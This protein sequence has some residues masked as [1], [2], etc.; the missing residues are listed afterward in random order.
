MLSRFAVDDST[1]R[2]YLAQRA[3]RR[4]Q[5]VP[6]P[7]FVEVLG[8]TPHSASF[9]QNALASNVG[10]P[11]DT[12]KLEQDLSAVVG[13]GRFSSLN[14][15]MVQRNGM[16]GLQIEG[17]EKTFAP[18]I[19]QPG[20]F[21]DGSQYN[22]VLFSI[23]ARLT[24]LDLGGYRSEW[25]TDV[26]L[27]STYAVDSEYHKFLSPKSRWF[28]EPRIFASSSPLEL[29]SKG[30]RLAQYGVGQ[31]GAE[32]DVGYEFH[33]KSELR[34]GYTMG[35]YK[36]DL[37]IGEPD[38][39]SASGR[40]SATSVRYTLDGV[41]NPVIPRTGTYLTSLFQYVDHAPTVARGF[42]SG[43]LHAEFFRKVSKP[44]S[45]FFS[46]DGGTTFGRQDAIPQFFLGG[47]LRLGAYGRNEIRTNQYFLFRT[48]Y[49]HQIGKL[50]PLFGEKI[51]VLGF[52]E[53]AKT[54]GGSPPSRLPTD[55]N[56][57]V[58]INTLFGPVFLGAAYG[59]TGH[60]KIYFQ[61]GRI[62]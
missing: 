8:T 26:T 37:R 12:G 34:A 7:Q 4:V 52:Y 13:V 32:F 28:Y 56:G 40:Q 20:I 54:Y 38:L 48:G 45:V 42:Y 21:I 10:K 17:D 19:L 24:L 35:Y 57:G 22:D 43:E 61:L 11:L 55:V 59:D 6:T 46:A 16:D 51:Y 31:A 39:P 50:S 9:V 25:Q 60:S 58:V 36:E 15:A 14:Y 23:G 2:Q 47:G 1:W 62:F 27:G 5:T 18:P 30:T 29:Y 49:L 44:G 53:V 3:A 33:R 41:D